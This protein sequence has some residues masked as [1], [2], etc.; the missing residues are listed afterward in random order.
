MKIQFRPLT[1]LRTDLL[2]ITTELWEILVFSPADGALI[3]H[4][5]T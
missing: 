5:T 1:A 3:L 4:M 2:H